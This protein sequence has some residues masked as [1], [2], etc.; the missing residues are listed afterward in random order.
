[1][2]LRYHPKIGT[3]VRVDYTTGFIEPEMVKRRL[4]L[5]VS[6]EMKGRNGLC[7][8]VP[9]STTAPTPPTP[10]HCQIDPD[11]EIPDPWGNRPRWVKAD[12][13]AGL[14]FAR[15]DLLTL[16]KGRD[17]KRVYQTETISENDL[18]RVRICLLAALGLTAKGQ[19]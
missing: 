19:V 9:L 13:V 10:F 6:K 11:L 1:M 16:G 5:V 8:V 15:L 12:L 3:I 7:T 17:G 18:R 2:G 14:S 4:G